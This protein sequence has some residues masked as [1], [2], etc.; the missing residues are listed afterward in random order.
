MTQVRCGRTAHVERLISM[1]K[2]V[3]DVDVTPFSLE[4]REGNAQ[5]LQEVL[6][7]KLCISLIHT[8]EFGAAAGRFSE[9]LRGQRVG[10]E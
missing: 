1:M 6:S 5:N 7:S 9:V 3:G 4:V 2:E 8:A 10:Y